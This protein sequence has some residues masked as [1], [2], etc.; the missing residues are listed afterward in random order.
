MLTFSVLSKIPMNNLSKWS[1]FNTLRLTWGNPE[2]IQSSATL[3]G[4]SAKAEAFG[5]NIRHLTCMLFHVCNL[6]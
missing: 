2:D 3:L 5:S 6:S 4:H 1:N